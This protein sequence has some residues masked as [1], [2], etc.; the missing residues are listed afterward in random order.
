MSLEYDTKALVDEVDH[1]Y[2]TP[3]IVQQRARTLEALDLRAGER[4]LDLGCGPGLLSLELG[5]A[6]GPGGSV[7]GIDR[8]A[9]MLSVA[10]ARCKHLAQI[11]FRTGSAEKLEQQPGAFDAVA[12]VQV[13]LYLHNVADVLGEIHRVLRPGGRVVIIETDW[14]SVVLNSSDSHLSRRMFSAWDGAVSS[15][16][17][18]PR[19]GALLHAAGFTQLRVE[20]IPIIGLHNSAD[21]FVGSIV[22]WVARNARD[23]SLIHI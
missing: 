3:E 6:V 11:E 9:E 4:V 12:C 14:R 5:E 22:D 17:L 10:R 23:L 16:N 2:R 21:N 20:A 18:P 7:V 19:L 1:S 15:P 8:S 13:L